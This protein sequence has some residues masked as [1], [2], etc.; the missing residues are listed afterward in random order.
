[1]AQ[2]LSSRMGAIVLFVA[3][4]AGLVIALYGY[5]TPLTGVDG[6]LGALVVILATIILAVLALVLMAV[7]GRGARNALRVLILLGLVGTFFAGLLL[8]LWGI[9]AA[10]V[11][12]LAGL[13]LDMA[14]PARIARSA[15]S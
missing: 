4:L 10:M 5:F 7:T 9:G 3:A 12:G 14:R 1:M 2:P 13:L 11:V 6:T 15:H 8:H